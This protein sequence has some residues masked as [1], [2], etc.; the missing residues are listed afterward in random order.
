MEMTSNGRCPICL[1]QKF[2]YLF[3]GHF[4]LYDIGGKKL[5][6][7]HCYKSDKKQAQEIYND[8]L[9]TCLPAEKIVV[10]EKVTKKVAETVTDEKKKKTAKRKST[11]Q[12]STVSRAQAK[13]EAPAFEPLR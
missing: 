3:N 6:C 11:K 13:H 5:D 8:M 10:E 4:M 1:D 12:K 2:V 7:P 9:N